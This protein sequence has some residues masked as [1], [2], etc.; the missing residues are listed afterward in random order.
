MDINKC[1]EFIKV[2]HEG[3]KRKQGTPYYMHPLSVCNML[4]EKGFSEEYQI[5][6]LFH[7]LIEDTDC[8][9]DEILALG[10]ENIVEAVRCVTKEPGYNMKDYVE[11]IRNNEMAK[12]VKL[13]DRVHNLSEAWTCGK[14]WAEK[15]IEETEIWYV[16]LSKGTVFEDDLKKVI[17]DLKTRNWRT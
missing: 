9:Y 17:L 7:D 10:N 4:K 14:E 1:I 15:Y 13:A 12:M 3:Q 2:K 5:A 8:I 6:G 11:R 16:D